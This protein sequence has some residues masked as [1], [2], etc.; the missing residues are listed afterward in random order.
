MHRI[1]IW[2]GSCVYAVWFVYF[3]LFCFGF[4][5]VSDFSSVMYALKH[6]CCFHFTAMFSFDA[7]EFTVRVFLLVNEFVLVFKPNPVTLKR[8]SEISIFPI[9]PTRNWNENQQFIVKDFWM[10]CL[11]FIYDLFQTWKIN[12]PKTYFRNFPFGIE[13]NCWRLADREGK[14]HKF[15][16]LHL[17]TIA[18]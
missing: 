10:K 5:C 15:C 13:S 7:D 11:Y 6:F 3:R 4:V 17:N 9:F 8:G 14:F 12:F 2:W 18:W 1:S 16:S